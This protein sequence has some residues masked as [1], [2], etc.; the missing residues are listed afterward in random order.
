MPC[1]G[2]GKNENLARK[3]KPVIKETVGEEAGNQA[4][5]DSQLNRESPPV[6]VQQ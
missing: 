1:I 5:R 3:T 6:P 2:H 4:E